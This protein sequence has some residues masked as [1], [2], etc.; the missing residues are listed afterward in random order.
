LTLDP[1]TAVA[2]LR[3]HVQRG[4]DALERCETI[5]ELQCRALQLEPPPASVSEAVRVAATARLRAGEVVVPRER[6]P[7]EARR[8]AVLLARLTR[9]LLP[10]RVD[11]E[12][13]AGSMLQ[14]A[15][16]SVLKD[17]GP[18]VLAAVRAV[19]HGADAGAALLR[20]CLKPELLRLSSPLRGLVAATCA[21]SAR[22][23][24]CGSR[25]AVVGDRAQALCRWCGLTW[26]WSAPA[27]AACGSTEKNRELD[28]SPIV[29]G[30]VLRQCPDCG[31]AMKLLP[32]PAEPLV[33]SL[34][35]ILASPL[36][37]AARLS[38]GARPTGGFALF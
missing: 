21:A 31:D 14:E 36:E 1:A 9:A 8:A 4:G 2:L 7:V 16:P 25:P 13:A 10:E 3:A 12:D 24:L 32:V 23:P 27:C 20:E 6:A 5:L 34:C 35:G 17:D 22:C 37:L 18:G 26:A 29:P 15:L 30:G 33:L 28:L 11:L 19:G 38:A